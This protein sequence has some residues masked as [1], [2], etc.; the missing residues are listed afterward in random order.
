MQDSLNALQSFLN[1]LGPK[2]FFFL[3]INHNNEFFRLTCN[4]YDTTDKDDFLLETPCTQC[5][6]SNMLEMIEK[7]VEEY[8]SKK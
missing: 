6:V 3:F 4:H 1:T 2:G 7:Y 8:T 5:G